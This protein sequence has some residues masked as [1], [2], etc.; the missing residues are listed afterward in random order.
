MTPAR[1]HLPGSLGGHPAIWPLPLSCCLESLVPDRFES[2]VPL[3]RLWLSHRVRGPLWVM[4]L[5]VKCLSTEFLFC[6]LSLCVCVCVCLPVCCLS[7]QTKGRLGLRHQISIHLQ[8]FHQPGKPDFQVSHP[9][10]LDCCPLTC[11]NMSEMERGRA[12]KSE[13]EKK[14]KYPGLWLLGGVQ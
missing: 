13:M 1:L 11:A 5:W 12:E 7:L 6:F 4:M 3:P 10:A 2:C 9:H 8:F 14:K